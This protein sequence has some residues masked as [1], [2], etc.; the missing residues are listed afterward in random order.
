MARTVLDVFLSSTANDLKPH[1]EAVYAR[2]A[3]IDFFR[4]VRQE[5]FGAQSAEALAFCRDKSRAA[6]LFVG[7][8]GM[9]RGWEPDGDNTKRSITEIEHDCAKDAGRRRFV[10]VSP[11]AFPVPGNL[12]ESRSE[13]RRQLAF[14][15]RIMAE[16]VVSQTG[17]DS[18][19]HLA[20]AIVEQLLSHVVTGDLIKFL[21]PEFANPGT[22]SVETPAPAIAAAVERLAEDKDV[23]LLALAK[24]PQGIDLAEL[25]TKLKERA[26]RHETAGR[27]ERKMSAEYWRHIGGFGLPPQHQ[28]RLC[29]LR[30][31]GRARSRGA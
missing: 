17:F 6:D 31:G 29:R 2:L 25:E 13:H 28:R 18:A 5:D 26:E 3:R 7:L 11:E 10:W 1:R 12:P 19:E 30:K 23:D 16:L 21:R 4:C 9:R 27:R 20:S 22:G 14:R 8:V 24:N 15:K